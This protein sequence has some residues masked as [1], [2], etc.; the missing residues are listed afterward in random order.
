MAVYI[1]PV[2]LLNYYDQRRVLEMCSDTGSPATLGSLG[3]N[4]LALSA[5]RSASAELD[6]HL[7]T[8]MRYERSQL[9]DICT[10]ADAGGSTE[11]E[12]K[13]AAPIKELVA[14]LAFG[15]LMARR[16]FAATK[17]RELAPMY[18][19]SQ[20]QLNLLASGVRIFDL[21]AP[22]A[23]G[24]PSRATIGENRL[25]WSNYSRMFGIFPTSPTSYLYPM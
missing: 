16:G 7:Q 10:A 23:A 9:E 19:T 18:E 24:V 2:E 4:P 6:S 12:K 21:D 17:M 3:S 13:R 15:R 11:A 20:E 25:K 22:K 14:H 8:G 5:I 1:T